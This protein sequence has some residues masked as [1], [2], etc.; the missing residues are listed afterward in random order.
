LLKQLTLVIWLVSHTV[1]IVAGDRQAWWEGKKPAVY[2]CSEI[3]VRM[4]LL[5][6]KAEP[7]FASQ[8]Q[9][10]SRVVACPHLDLQTSTC[11]ASCAA[12][13]KHLGRPERVS[14]KNPPDASA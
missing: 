8:L 4:Q 11:P 6:C 1:P 14:N 5:F 12:G 13:P 2:E 10:G 9:S 3:T 7:S